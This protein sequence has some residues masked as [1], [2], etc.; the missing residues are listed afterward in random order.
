MRHSFAVR[1]P[2]DLFGN[3]W[4]FYRWTAIGLVCF[5]LGCAAVWVGQTPAESDVVWPVNGILLGLLVSKPRREWAG[6]LASGFIANLLV[7]QVFHFPL[8]HSLIFSVANSVEVLVALPLVSPARGRRA[9]LTNWGCLWKFLVYGILFAPFCSAFTVE[10]LRW[11]CGDPAGLQGL[12]NWY[13]GDALGIAIMAPLALAIRPSELALLFNRSRRIESVGLISALACVSAVVFSQSKYPLEFLLFPALL[14]VIF[15]LR[16]SGSAIAVFLVILPA[17]YYTVHGQGPFAL[18]GPGPLVRSILLLQYF[19]GAM[20]VMVYSVSGTLSQRD[21]LLDETI[22]A[23]RNAEE[24]AGL[25]HLTGLS[26]RRHFDSVLMREWRKAIREMGTISLLMI[27]VDYFKAY[28]DLYGHVLGDAALRAVGT[29]IGNAPLRSS[30]F[31]AR[32]G[33]EEF[34][35]LLPG[36]SRTG[37]LFIAERI[38]EIVVQASMEHKGNPQNIVTLSI[39]VGTVAPTV[40]EGHLDLVRIAD[41][42]LYE[43]KR[44]GRNRVT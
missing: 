39:G 27:D 9:E 38:R 10:L 40:G 6:Y 3:A 20:I 2:T 34:A 24:H 4:Q 21:Q 18:I 19:F 17:T 13:L 23:Y 43:A 15:R 7:H 12:W 22:E 37:A 36:S 28:N 26:N 14:L 29:L 33:G 35:V 32:Y 1:R 42:A 31:T 30:D 25:D 44:G 5:V 41:A 11:L 16:G 8:V